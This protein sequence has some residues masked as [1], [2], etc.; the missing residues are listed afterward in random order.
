[1]LNKNTL[2]FLKNAL[3]ATIYAHVFNFVFN[4]IL[5]MGGIL[6]GVVF[7]LLNRICRLKKNLK[8]HFV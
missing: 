8:K 3:Y 4:F 7:D 5:I 6:V 2:L 1:M